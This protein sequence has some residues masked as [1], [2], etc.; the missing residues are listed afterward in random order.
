M[1]GW[2]RDAEVRRRCDELAAVEPMRKPRRGAQISQE[3]RN[4]SEKPFHPVGT[5]SPAMIS[6]HRQP[7]QISEQTV[8]SENGSRAYRDAEKTATRGC[9]E[10]LGLQMWSDSLG[11]FD[12]ASLASTRAPICGGCCLADWHLRRRLRPISRFFPR[13]S[14]HIHSIGERL[15]MGSTAIGPAPS[16]MSTWGSAATGR[17]IASTP[18]ASCSP[19]V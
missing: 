9:A 12:H 11:G 17:P 6:A 15:G 5:Q 13:P 2:M 18:V 8:R 16:R 1:T 4:P 3:R 10:R 19:I 14:I 7:G